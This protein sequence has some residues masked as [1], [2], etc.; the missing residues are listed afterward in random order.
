MNTTITPGNALTPV[1]LPPSEPGG[2]LPGPAE[3]ST[4]L[5]HTPKRVTGGTPRTVLMRLPSQESEVV[6][7]PFNPDYWIHDFYISM[8]TEEPNAALACPLTREQRS[9]MLDFFGP[10]NLIVDDDMRII[11]GQTTQNPDTVLGFLWSAR[12]GKSWSDHYYPTLTFRRSGH[13]LEV[14]FGHMRYFDPERGYEIILSSVHG[15]HFATRMR[16]WTQ[17]QHLQK[18]IDIFF[19][20]YQVCKDSIGFHEYSTYTRAVVRRKTKSSAMFLPKPDSPRV[21]GIKTGQ[22]GFAAKTGPHHFQLPAC[23]KTFSIAPGHPNPL[24]LHSVRSAV[25]FGI[26]TT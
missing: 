9:V 7:D 16:D 12:Y 22:R 6:Y 26:K 18:V 17:W 14:Q 25:R 10:A 2:P 3:P 1:T 5:V 13:Q 8:S 21:S 11:T 4:A 15:N 23:L 19:P 24:S 20:E